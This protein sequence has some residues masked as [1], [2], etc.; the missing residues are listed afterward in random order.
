MITQRGK[1]AAVDTHGRG[2]WHL[3]FPGAAALLVLMTALAVSQARAVP[4]LFTE[5][6]RS[7]DVLPGGQLDTGFEALRAASINDAGEVAFIGRYV[8]GGQVLATGNGGTLTTIYE[9]GVPASTSDSLGGYSSI[10]S[11]G[12]VAF[13]ADRQTPSGLMSD[14]C[15]G[16]GGAPTTLA[17]APM[18]WVGQPI[19]NDNG[20]VVYGV[21]QELVPGFYHDTIYVADP[22]AV[23]P[24][25]DSSGE[26][27]KLNLN[28]AINDSDQVAW[29][30]HF[31]DN[32]EAIYRT[33]LSGPSVEIVNTATSPFDFLYM[34][35]LI[36]DLNDKGTVAFHAVSGGEGGIYTS[37]GGGVTTIVDGTG[38]M[39]VLGGAPSINNAGTVA[40]R[41]E[42]DSSK[43]IVYGIFT[44]P[45]AA[46][47]TVVTEQQV[48]LGGVSLQ[49][50]HYR[51]PGAINT[52]GQIAFIGR[53]YQ[54]GVSPHLAIRADPLGSTI[55]F[56]VILTGYG[57]F[58][59]TILNDPEAPEGAQA[60]PDGLG[61]AAPIYLGLPGAP[62]YSL[63]VQGDRFA[64]ILIPGPD[65]IPDWSPEAL[66]G[67]AAEG[68]ESEVSSDLWLSVTIGGVSYP[69]LPGRPFDITSIYPDGVSSLTVLGLDPASPFVPGVTFMS[70]E[71]MITIYATAVPEPCTITL[72]GLGTAALIRRRRKGP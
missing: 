14:A 71:G 9:A 25:V 60:L 4:Y 54:P 50:V 23:S 67:P 31:T 12:T 44:G 16:S 52:S 59:M 22:P 28:A 34:E 10:N 33:D 51:G 11:N 53:A 55:P 66:L 1:E 48:I 61:H 49:E 65:G 62:G 40:F 47:D 15:Y 6:A 70:A 30:G 45:N 35:D 21:K 29:V 64:S 56:P 57:Q 36:L 19:I 37:N 8:G 32:S 26:I 18:G 17:S 68:G 42:Y 46:T 38:S 72:L 58:L 7:G 24:V 63:T 2:E 41:A 43:Y 13:L 69:V 39:N 27:Y 5:I 3:S 20:A